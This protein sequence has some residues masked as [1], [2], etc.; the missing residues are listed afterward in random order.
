MAAIEGTVDRYLAELDR[1]D[2]QHEVTGVP[3]P[4]AKVERLKRG[5][6]TLK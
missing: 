6:E 4:A 3:L 1:V 5:I 2:R